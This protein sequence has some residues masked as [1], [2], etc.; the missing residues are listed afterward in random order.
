MLI[1]VVID[2]NADKFPAI[3]IVPGVYGWQV[4]RH[5][6]RVYTRQAQADIAIGFGLSPN[7]D[8]FVAWVIRPMAR[9]ASWRFLFCIRR[10]RQRAAPTLLSVLARGV[11]VWAGGDTLGPCAFGGTI[12]YASHQDSPLLEQLRGPLIRPGAPASRR[13]EFFA[14]A[15]ISSP[16]QQLSVRA[17]HLHPQTAAAQVLCTP[18]STNRRQIWRSNYD[19]SLRDLVETQDLFKKA[20]NFTRS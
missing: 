15:L 12:R 5:V 8:I 9:K 2:V 10:Q 3:D 7:S 20:R 14:T 18:K 11:A 4:I 13:G 16:L 6:L 19:N 1:A 17:Q